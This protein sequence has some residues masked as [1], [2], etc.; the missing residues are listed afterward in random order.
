VRARPAIAALGAVALA[1]AGLATAAGAGPAAGDDAAARA[2]GVKLKRV[3]SFRTP[4]YVAGAPG[5]PRLVFVVEQPGRVRVIRRGRVL[6]RPFL[7]IRGLVRSNYEEG[8]F[9]IAFHPGY[10]R[11][12]LFYVFFVDNGG[13]I[14]VEELKRARPLRAARGSRRTVMRIRHQPYSTHMGGQLQFGGRLLY[15]SVGDGGGVGDPGDDAKDRR[16]LLGK[17]LRIDP[18]NPRGRARFRVPRSNPFVG[19]RGRDTI[20]SYGLRNPWRFSFDRTSARRPRLVIADVGQERWEEID[21]ETLR[22]ARGAFFGWDEYEGFRPYECDGRCAHRREPPVLVYGRS[23]GCSIIGG[24]VVRDRR[25]RGLY[26]RY[27]FTDL[28]QGAIRSVALRLG[29]GRRARRTGL[30]VGMPVSFGE[31]RRGRVYVVSLNGAVYRI[32][33]A[34][35]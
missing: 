3:G 19:R 13:D 18:R 25:L 23:R 2:A 10:K 24:Y 35:R 33:P 15:V 30:R 31:D 6:R 14:R 9:S 32:D 27:L 4:V 8:L 21:Y 34:R 12:R 5:F 11:N 28:C 7:D 22:S 20:W 16:S 1:A 26:G 17:I 29:G